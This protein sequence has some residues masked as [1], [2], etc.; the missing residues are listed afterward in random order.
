MD[1]ERRLPPFAEDALVI[2]REAA[3]EADAGLPKPAAKARL[4]DDDRFTEADAEHA[5]ELL[6][7]R[8]HIYYV[9]DRVR[10]TPIDE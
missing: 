8:G 4:A 5:L 7:S 10:I 9:D 3:G 1:W 2:L 6:Q